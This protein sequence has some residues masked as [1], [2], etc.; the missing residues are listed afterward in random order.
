MPGVLSEES[1]VMG[2][3]AYFRCPR[4]VREIKVTS[5]LLVFAT[6]T[7]MYTDL[8]SLT[9]TS[10]SRITRPSGICDSL[11]RTN[12]RCYPAKWSPTCAWT[13]AVVICS[14]AKCIP[15]YPVRTVPT[16]W[17]V[18]G[19]FSNVPVNLAVFTDREDSADFL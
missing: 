11:L 6:E 14:A 1:T 17:L 15:L 3:T 4:M 16:L 19:T 13:Y 12:S 9:V 7:G 18:S 8:H 10:S 5:S 2:Y